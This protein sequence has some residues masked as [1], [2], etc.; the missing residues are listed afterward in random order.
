[1]GS[2][3]DI[4]H[5]EKIRNACTSYGIPCILRVTSAHKGPDETLRI[6]A[7]Y[8]GLI[9]FERFG[10]LRDLILSRVLISSCC[11]SG[12]GVPTV[13][14][15]VAG[16]S[17]GLGPV[18]SGNTAFPVINCPPLTPDWGSQDVWSSL[19]MPSGEHSSCIENL[20]TYS[21]QYRNHILYF[22]HR[23]W[24]FY[25]PLPWGRCSVRS[26]DLWLDWSPCLEQIEGLHAQHMG[27]SQTGWQEASGLQYLNWLTITGVKPLVF[28]TLTLVTISKPCNSRYNL[29]V[30]S[31]T[32][33]I[34]IKRNDKKLVK[35]F[36][37]CFK[38]WQKK[39]K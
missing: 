17:N 25:N 18:M 24:V 30:L 39:W 8:E 35:C 32:Q 29:H 5:C 6:K 13:F 14:V 4:A 21:V 1:M 11:S 38:M 23:S 3:S 16:R 36:V 26:T 9:S 7:E 28:I 34:P 31:H 19:R 27:G 20:F 22:F 37:W 2:T 15:A 10:S 12:D 33:I